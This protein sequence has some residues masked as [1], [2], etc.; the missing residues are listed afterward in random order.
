MS[1]TLA[2]IPASL[3]TNPMDLVKTR[4]QVASRPGEVIYT[5]IGD[6]IRKVYQNE[7]PAAFLKGSI[8]RVCRIAPQFGISL[9][10]YEKLSQLIGFK[11]IAPPTNAPVNP[12]DYRAAFSSV[13]SRI[14]M[15]ALDAENLIETIGLFKP[16]RP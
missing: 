16:P 11:G 10:A 15:K 4:L 7:G 2:A 6:C 8:P 12:H 1:G 5:G 3:L 14:E 9:F 13:S